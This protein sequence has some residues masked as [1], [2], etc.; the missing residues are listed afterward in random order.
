MDILDK[1]Q[2]EKIVNA[3]GE[4]WWIIKIEEPEANNPRFLVKE[5]RSLFN[6]SKSTFG[7]SNR[8]FT[9]RYINGGFHISFMNQSTGFLLIFCN[10]RR[11]LDKT[12]LR[13]FA[14]RYY[15]STKL[16]P[17][18]YIE[19]IKKEDDSDILR[20]MNE[21]INGELEDVFNAGNIPKPRLIRFGCYFGN[22][23]E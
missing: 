8:Q 2:Y 20:Q 12:F 22:K 14:M 10:T 4:N 17:K 23:N 6:S 19:Q 15:S 16:L 21:I 1:V 13:H 11:D 5:F 9:S 3:G 7:F 18:L